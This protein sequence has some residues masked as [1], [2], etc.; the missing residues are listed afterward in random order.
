MRYAWWVVALVCSWAGLAVGAA[1]V[2][3]T[4]DNYATW[5]RLSLSDGACQAKLPRSPRCEQIWAGAGWSVQ[6]AREVTQTLRTIA[7]ALDELRAGGDKAKRAFEIL[8]GQSATSVD[9]ALR[10]RDQLRA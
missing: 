1:P 7:E 9:T 6:R 3:V 5:Y 2:Q 4:E 8:R 10:H